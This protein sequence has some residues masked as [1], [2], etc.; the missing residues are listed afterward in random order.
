MDP[1]PSATESP[2]SP[3]IVRDANATPAKLELSHR[4]ACMNWPNPSAIPEVRSAD[5]LLQLLVLIADSQGRYYADPPMV[6]RFTYGQDPRP[7]ELDYYRWRDNLIARGDITLTADAVNCYGMCVELVANI[8]RLN[9]F[10][11]WAERPPIP[12]AVRAKVFENDNH[13]CVT[14]GATEQLEV[15]HVIP[16][17]KGG[18]HDISNF[19]TLCKPCNMRKG[20]RVP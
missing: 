7:T 10:Q 14:C 13:S 11:R 3:Q 17:S 6:L 12:K 8:Q 1:R 9:R 20:A 16:W 4:L 18:A 19:Q 2:Q 5:D 15:D